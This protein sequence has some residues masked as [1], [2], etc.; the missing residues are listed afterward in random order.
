MKLAIFLQRYFPYGGLQRDSVRL[1]EAAFEAGHEVAIVVATWEGPKPQHIEVRELHSGGQSNHQKSAQ[2]ASACQQIMA[3]F[4]VTICFSRVPGCDFHF[5][6]DPCYAEKFARQKPAILRLLPRYRFLH[7]N[8]AAVFGPDSPTHLF[9]LAASEIPPYQEFYH[10]PET[11]MTLLPPWLK[12]TEPF[13]QSAADLKAATLKSMNLPA[14]SEM[15]LFVGSDFQ[16]K[17]LDRA[18]DAL[19]EVKQDNLHLVVC[20]QDQADPYRKQAQQLGIED[21]VH[22]LGPRDDVPRL[23]A[24]AS[25]LVHPA[26]QETAGMVLLEALSYGLPVLCTENCGYASHVQD[27]G[28]PPLHTEIRPSELA[29]TIRQSLPLLPDLKAQALAWAENA[30]QDNAASIMLEKMQQSL[31]QNESR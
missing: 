15:L 31:E 23:M 9:F 13:S 29:E 19:A 24:S 12:K 4:D 17:G 8:E 21:R 18:I 1:A 10:I 26:R 16:R 2:F 27:A 3:E 30:Y 11:Q 14:D 6:G 28:C 22:L 25:L 7:A 5:C 20:G